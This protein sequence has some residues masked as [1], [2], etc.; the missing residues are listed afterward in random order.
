MHNSVFHVVFAIVCTPEHS[1]MCLHVGSVIGRLSKTYSIEPNLNRSELV[2]I[3]RPLYNSPD[4][5]HAAPRA[6]ICPCNHY[7]ALVAHVIAQAE[8][9]MPRY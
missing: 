6:L 2:I 8:T 9:F 3:C 4:Q 5:L 7:M 1:R